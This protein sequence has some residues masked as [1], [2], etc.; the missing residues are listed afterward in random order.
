MRL[1]LDKGSNLISVA[2]Q[3]GFRRTQTCA[4]PAIMSGAG[5]T[6]TL[7]SRC[8]A[9]VRFKAYPAKSPFRFLSIYHE[10]A[11]SRCGLTDGLPGYFPGGSDF[12]PDGVSPV[13]RSTAKS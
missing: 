1:V 13:G 11:A 5:R 9:D 3:V 12:L 2:I 6:E 10:P 7:A 8:K 4:G